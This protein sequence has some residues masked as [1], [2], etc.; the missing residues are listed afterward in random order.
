M[1]MYFAV[2]VF[3]SQS[4]NLYYPYSTHTDLKFKKINHRKMFSTNILSCIDAL[5]HW[6]NIQKV[7]MIWVINGIAIIMGYDGVKPDFPT[8]ET[9]SLFM[10]DSYTYRTGNV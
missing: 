3:V 9:I 5:S 2:C 8:S 4:I 10:C 1:L 6:S 7:I